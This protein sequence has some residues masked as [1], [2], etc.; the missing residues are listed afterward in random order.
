MNSA[1]AV[2]PSAA[3]ARILIPLLHLC[4]TGLHASL[5]LNE[6]WSVPPHFSSMLSFS[7]S[8][9]L[10]RELPALLHRGKILTWCSLLLFVVWN[11]FKQAG[12]W[13]LCKFSLCTNTRASAHAEIPGL[14]SLTTVLSKCNHLWLCTCGS[15]SSRNCC[16][17]HSAPP[18]TREGSALLCMGRGNFNEILPESRA[19]WFRGGFASHI[20]GPHYLA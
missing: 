18:L 13:C 16:A 20:C 14:I 19:R 2:N 10:S 5:G 1:T 11:R 6:H 3:R 9:S 8:L 7:F 4:T 12:S 17:I 15:R